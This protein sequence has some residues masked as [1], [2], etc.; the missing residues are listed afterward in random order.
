M[1]VSLSHQSKTNLLD[2]VGH[3]FADTLIDEIKAG[4]KLQG[5]GDNWDLRINVHE[6]QLGNQN[7]DLHY[8]ASSLIVERVPS[9]DLSAVAPRKDVRSLANSAFLLNSNES[10]KLREDFKVLVGRVLVENVTH[11]SFMKSIIPTHIPHDYQREMALQSVI[12]PLSMQLKD[13]KKYDDVVDIL[14]YYEQE[15][16][17]IYAKAGVIQKPAETKGSLNQQKPTSI[18]GLTSAAD[19]P[20]AHCNKADENDH[21]KA[22]TVPFGGDQMTRV[23]FAGAKDLRSGAHTAKE[24]LDHCSP[25]FSAPFHTKMAFVQVQNRIYF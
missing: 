6:M 18:E 12:V 11:L 9:K 5:V 15:L 3:H 13:E 21:M 14:D 2:I 4:K 8:F 19:Q 25:F 10:M 20:G 1:G 16:E 22:I 24:R 23:R 7:I 17:D